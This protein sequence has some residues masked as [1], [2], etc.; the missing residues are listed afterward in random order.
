MARGWESKSV[1][2]QIDTARQRQGEHRVRL[3]PEQLEAERKRDSIRLQCTRMK[4]QLENCAEG[5]YRQTL[6]EGLQFL[7]KQLADLG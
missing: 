1:E 7:E 3:T 4:N 5:R 2:Q 6:E